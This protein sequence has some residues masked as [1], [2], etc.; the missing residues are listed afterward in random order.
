MLIV[1]VVVVL[2]VLVVV[3]VVGPLGGET[4]LNLFAPATAVSPEA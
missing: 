1:V 4:K 3:V 2:I